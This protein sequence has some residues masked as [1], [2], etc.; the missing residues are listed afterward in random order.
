MKLETNI[1]GELQSV[2]LSRAWLFDII[3]LFIIQ[4]VGTQE[5]VKQRQNVNGSVSEVTLYYSGQSVSEVVGPGD[6]TN[7]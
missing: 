2:L 6:W 4:C 1:P 7:E 3:H 5:K